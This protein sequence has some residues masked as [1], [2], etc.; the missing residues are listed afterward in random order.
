MTLREAQARVE[1]SRLTLEVGRLLTT[2]RAA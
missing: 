1:G 2:A